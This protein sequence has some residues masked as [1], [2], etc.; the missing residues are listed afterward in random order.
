MNISFIST[1]LL[2]S[3]PDRL[4][5]VSE[6]QLKNMLC[7]S[8]VAEVSILERSAVVRAVKLL[9]QL[10]VL[11]GLIVSITVEFVIEVLCC[12]QGIKRDDNFSIPVYTSVAVLPSNCS[13]AL[14]T[15]LRL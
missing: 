4:R 2:V 5:E 14:G 15:L 7:I 6:V 10:D 3:S 8:L 13:P 12:D 1:T 9:N 11:I